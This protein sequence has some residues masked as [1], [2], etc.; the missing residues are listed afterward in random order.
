MTIITTCQKLKI[1][2]FAAPKYYGKALKMVISG[3]H[4]L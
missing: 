1:I 4:Y 2:V 3:M